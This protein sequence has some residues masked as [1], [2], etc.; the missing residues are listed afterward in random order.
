MRARTP[1]VT[2][3]PDGADIV[4][5]T[6]MHSERFPVEA[7]GSRLALYRWLRD[8]EAGRY[9]RFFAADVAALEAAKAELEGRG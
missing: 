9:R 7:L 8:R 5:G 1:T 2:V 6:V 4:F 3:S